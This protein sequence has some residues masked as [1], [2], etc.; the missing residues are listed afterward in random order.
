MKGGKWRR[1]RGKYESDGRHTYDV[2]VIRH[3]SSS[4][5]G[6]GEEGRGRDD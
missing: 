1:K 4:N 2:D 5:V 6:N 3:G